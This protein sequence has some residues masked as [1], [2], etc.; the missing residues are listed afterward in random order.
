MSSIATNQN[1]DINALFEAQ[2]KT[3]RWSKMS[4]WAIGIIAILLVAAVGA[5]LTRKAAAGKPS[6]YQTTAVT[7]GNLNVSVSATGNLAPTN[8]V[9]VGS[10]LSGIVDAV[11]VQENDHV[12]KGQVL[13]RLDPSKLKDAITQADATL[14]S[15]QAKLVQA[16]ATLKESQVSLD[17]YREVSRLSGGK[18]PSKTEMTTAETTF[19]KAEADLTNQRAAVAEANAELSTAKI[20]LYKSEIRSPI[21][22]VILTRSVEPGQTVAATLQVAT[23]FTVAEDLREMELKVYVDEADVGSVLKGQ[24]ATFSVDAYPNR[25]YKAG[26][27][28]VAYGSTTKDNVV[29]YSTVLKVKNDD[30]SLRPGMTATASIATTARKNVLLVPNTALRFTPEATVQTAKKGFSIFPHPPDSNAQKIVNPTMGS[31]QQVWTLREGRPVAIPVTVGVTDGQRTEVISAELHE[32]M[33]IITNT[34]SETK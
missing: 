4:R 16:E 20:N 30:L 3:R 11:L 24:D 26:V 6:Q 10:E 22:G 27:S 5:S 28:R 14:A 17:R 15:A 19:A 9:D 7:R 2:G 31:T 32:G 25:A 13:A 23:L 8:K 21:N 18:V 1:K 29:S 12:I 34:A 33:P